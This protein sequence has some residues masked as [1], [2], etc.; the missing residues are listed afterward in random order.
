MVNKTKQFYIMIKDKNIIIVNI[1]YMLSYAFQ[2]LNKNNYEDISKESFEH[3][4]DLFA[5]I[6]FRGVSEQLKQGLYREYIDYRN[7]L[8]V[9]KS[10]LIINE[11][12]SNI[13]QHKHKLS[14]EYD[15]LSENNALNQILKS[16]IIL[17]INNKDLQHKQKSQLR[18]IISFFN[19]VD[20]INV[21]NIRWN[22]LKFQRNNHTYKTLINIC[23]F[24]IDSTIM[25]TDVGSYHMT[26]FYERHMNKLFERF[27]RNYYKKHYSYL[28]PNADVIKWNIDNNNS[29][30]TEF[31]PQMHSDVVLH[32]NS[33]TLIIDTK[34]YGEIMQKQFNKKIIHSE[35]IYQIFSYV[36]NYDIYNSG[37]VSGLLLYAKT[38]ED[39]LPNLDVNICNNRIMTQTL[40]LNKKFEHISKQLDDIVTMFIN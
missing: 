34:Y 30:K 8:S 39:I 20:E 5:E 40:D 14:C 36:K 32:N 15:E 25:T 17:L 33:H 24:I 18:S 2:E 16:T 7:N 35:H 1:Y 28:K 26:T 6:L 13:I 10:R 29:S 9:L 12:I 22:K 31:L 27:V 3:I 4:V 11:T 19:N 21:R 37:N 38:E 23:F